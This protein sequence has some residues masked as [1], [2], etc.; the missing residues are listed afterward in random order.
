MPRSFNIRA[1]LS[2]N[3]RNPPLGE[4]PQKQC[5]EFVNPY[6]IIANRELSLD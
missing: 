4:F 6:K 2:A 1:S 5:F 3:K